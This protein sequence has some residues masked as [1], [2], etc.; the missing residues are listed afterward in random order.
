MR[1]NCPSGDHCRH[2]HGEGQLRHPECIGPD[3]ESPREAADL[4]E[5]YSN[6]NSSSP[7]KDQKIDSR[8]SINDDQKVDDQGVIYSNR[9]SVS[10]SSIPTS[11]ES[12]VQKH[13]AKEILPSGRFS[14]SPV[15]GSEELPL[16]GDI[17]NDEGLESMLSSGLPNQESHIPGKADLL[18]NLSEAELTAA[19]SDLLL[20]HDLGQNDTES[21]EQ[22]NFNSEREFDSLLGTSQTTEDELKRLF[23]A[24]ASTDSA[25]FKISGLYETSELHRF[26]SKQEQESLPT[27]PFN[28]SGLG[29]T[30]GLTTTPPLVFPLPD[31]SAADMKLNDI[32]NMAVAT[33]DPDLLECSAKILRASLQYKKKQQ[34]QQ[35]QQQNSFFTQASLAPSTASTNI[36]SLP[37]SP[38]IISQSLALYG[39]QMFAE[40]VA[41]DCLWNSE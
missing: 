29:T 1:G 5:L 11:P 7:Q 30:S 4:S 2:A 24:L 16:D 37:A 25:P 10:P 6:Q 14:R 40:N 19:V 36:S 38:R 13:I 27:L 41:T 32:L 22:S 9:V 35:Q 23:E 17:C 21:G 18:A 31:E 15:V 34:Q 26:I 39:Q 33:Q 20:G 28:L 12:S 3:D 8:R